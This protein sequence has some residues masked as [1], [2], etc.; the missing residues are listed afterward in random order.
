MATQL[1]LRG[2]AWDHPRARNPLEAISR[3]WAAERNAEVTWEARPLKDFEDQ[4]LEELADRYDMVLMDYPF[5]ATAADSGLIVPVNDWVSPTY[6]LDQATNSVGPSFASYTWNN[7]Q[8]ALAV[9][10]ACQVSAMRADQFSSGNVGAIPDTWNDVAELASKRRAPAARVAMPL[11]PNHAYCAFVS[12]GLGIANDH[13]WPAGGRIDMEAGVEALEFLRQL[14]RDLHPVSRIE[15]P[16]G[17]SDL[18]ATTDEILYVPLMFGYSSY[19]RAGFRKHIIRFAN[20]PRGECG[21]RGSVLGGVGFALSSRSAHRDAAAE[22]GRRIASPEVQSGMYAES[23][24]QPGHTAAWESAL[25]NGQAL[26]FFS[27]T[28]ETID[29][30]FLRPRVPGHR[31]FQ[32]QAGQLIHDFIWSADTSAHK[33]V[34]ACRKLM[35]DLMPDWGNGELN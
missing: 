26:N 18:M 22:L 21:R 9:D 19:S 27:A 11:N 17:I 30:A 33:C 25:V 20:A 12:V 4:P 35:D 1:K 8:W 2:M 3:Q 7:R 32:P 15:D 31:R 34:K 13:F 29:Q 28:R 24:G 6:L 16:I 5:T 14:A 23:G 10:A